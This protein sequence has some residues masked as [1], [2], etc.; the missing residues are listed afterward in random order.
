[1]R[2]LIV[3]HGDPDYDRDILT[4]KGEKEV[5]LLVPRMLKEDIKDF[6]V[7]PMRRAR[8]TA[9][10]TLN[11]FKKTAQIKDWMQEFIYPV[12]I[13]GCTDLQKAYPD[14][15]VKEDGTFEDR[16]AWDAVPSYWRTKPELATENG[17]RESEVAA[18]APTLAEN[19]DRVCAGFDE[20]LASYGYVRDGHL[21][22]TEQGTNDTI[23]IF[24]HLGLTCVLLSH[25]WGIS[26][27]IL[28]HSLAMAPTSVTEI[29]T[30]EREKGIVYFRASRIGDISHL[31][32]AG[33][34]PA[35][36]ARFCSVYEND[37]RH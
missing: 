3:R 4:E 11:A 19:Y 17:W 2:L 22:R 10:P 5:Q 25:L 35:F 37:E 36:A 14:T 12:D 7:S 18:H 1:M 21:Y 15:P 33:E 23:A 34:Q 13:N 30:E 28:W 26:P 16:L 20:L 24:C 32:A 6:Y 27:F 9:Q 31:Y 8:M 29:N